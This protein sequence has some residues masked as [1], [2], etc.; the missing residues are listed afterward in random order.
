[1]YTF[2]LVPGFFIVLHCRSYTDSRGHGK[3]SKKKLRLSKAEEGIP[4]GKNNFKELNIC[5][6]EVLQTVEVLKYIITAN[7]LVTHNVTGKVTCAFIECQEQWLLHF[8]A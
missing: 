7:P 8:Y 5:L 4:V 2:W 6:E 1:M 3:T